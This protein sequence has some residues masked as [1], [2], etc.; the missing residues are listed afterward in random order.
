MAI[1][2]YFIPIIIYIHILK[3][4][5]VKVVKDYKYNGITKNTRN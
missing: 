4:H 1:I 2:K 3:T 5:L